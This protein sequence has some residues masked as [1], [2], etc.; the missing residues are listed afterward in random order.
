MIKQFNNLQN[1]TKNL[2][3]YEKGCDFLEQIALNY[4]I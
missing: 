1:Y 4:S 2:V 3:I